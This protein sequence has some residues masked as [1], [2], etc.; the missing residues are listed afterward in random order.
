MNDD[1]TLFMKGAILGYCQSHKP[2]EVAILFD[3]VFLTLDIEKAANISAA[4]AAKFLF[5]ALN[6]REDTKDE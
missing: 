5:I 2:E 3:D 6:V 1:T 4:I